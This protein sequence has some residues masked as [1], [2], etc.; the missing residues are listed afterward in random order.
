MLLYIPDITTIITTII[1][2]K[3]LFKIQLSA[4]Q[5]KFPLFYNFLQ[6]SN[7]FSDSNWILLVILGWSFHFHFLKIHDE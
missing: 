1:V 4:T 5:F 2:K 7:F 6:I 3:S